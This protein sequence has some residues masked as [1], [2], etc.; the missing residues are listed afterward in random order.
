MTR[1]IEALF[2]RVPDGWAF[3][4]NPTII[5]RGRV[6]LL[7]DAQKAELTRRLRIMRWAVL[8]GFLVLAGLTSA[9]FVAVSRVFGGSPFVTGSSTL[10][11]A[12]G[13]LV[14][15]G[16]FL[17]YALLVRRIAIAPVIATAPQLPVRR[18]FGDRMRQQAR[19]FSAKWRI[20]AI[21]GMLIVC[22]GQLWKWTLP[23]GTAIN[24]IIAIVFAVFA[25]QHIALLVL[26][27]RTRRAASH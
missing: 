2:T 12:G 7:D 27:L 21:A 11:S 9:L 24:L 25:L 17:G 26:D 22:A 23:S 13:M 15:A 19:M 14:T 1:W 6:Y 20:V 10:A 16:A 8:L 3:E 5:G 18:T 4:A